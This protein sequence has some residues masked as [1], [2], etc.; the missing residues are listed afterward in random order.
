MIEL[1]LLSLAVSFVCRGVAKKGSLSVF[2]I[3]T[4]MST[5]AKR[6]R[7]I[8]LSDKDRRLRRMPLHRGDEDVSRNVVQ[9]AGDGV[10]RSDKVCQDRFLAVDAAAKLP[11]ASAGLSEGEV[12]GRLALHLEQMKR[13]EMQQWKEEVE[14]DVLLLPGRLGRSKRP[15]TQNVQLGLKRWHV[16]VPLSRLL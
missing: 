6:R 12:P 14:E 1:F 7:E 3:G 13:W 16:A 4:S 5:G 11:K 9:C 10:V 8:S 15:Q 2:E